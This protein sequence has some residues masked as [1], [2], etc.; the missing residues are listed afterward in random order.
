MTGMRSFGAEEEL[1]IVDP[2]TGAP[3]PLVDRVL[4]VMGRPRDVEREFKL[5]QVEIQ[6]EPCL[7][8]EELLGH[9]PL[10]RLREKAK[11]LLAALEETP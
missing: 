6:T 8:H 1:L 11:E 4:A 5:E 2:D 10:E 9:D 7:T 3:Q